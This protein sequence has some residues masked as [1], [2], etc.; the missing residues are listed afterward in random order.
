MKL[1]GIF[2]ENRPEW[3]ITQLACCSDSICIV[4][5][6]REPQ[7]IDVD[8]IVSLVGKTEIETIAVSSETV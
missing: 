4:P 1:I 8:R 3:Y 7:F 5:V 6:A 2:S